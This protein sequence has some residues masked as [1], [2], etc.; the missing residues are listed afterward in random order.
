MVMVEVQDLSETVAH[1]NAH[2]QQ[3][4]K[5]MGK[6]QQFVRSFHIVTSVA[7]TSCVMGTWE[8]L[9]A[10]S[11]PALV[12]GGTAGLFWSCIWGYSGQSFIVLSLAE[13]ASMA[14]TAG[15]QYHWVNNLI[16]RPLE[17]RAETCI[18]VRVCTPKIPEGVELHFRL[19][20]YPMLA[21]FYNRQLLHLWRDGT[22]DDYSDQRGICTGTMASNVTHHCFRYM[23]R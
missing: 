17:H 4:M 23:C 3:D 20:R 8:L 1:T 6:K 21:V 2:D 5:R 11:P 19:A 16:F 15:G 12:A 9:L 22:I 10:T 13:M 7:F 18:G 14:P